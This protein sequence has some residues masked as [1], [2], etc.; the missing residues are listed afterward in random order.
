M[1][2]KEWNFTHKDRAQDHHIGRALGT[3]VVQ[4]R[5]TKGTALRMPSEFYDVR[6]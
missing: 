2:M 1:K 5:L 3:G 4:D 6:P